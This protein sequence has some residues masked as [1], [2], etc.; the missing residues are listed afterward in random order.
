MG[1]AQRGRDAYIR[2]MNA[3]P[4]QEEPLDVEHSPKDEIDAPLDSQGELGETES[5]RLQ[6]AMDRMSKTMSTLSNVE[7]KIDDTD[8]SL[9]Q[10]LK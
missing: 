4:N 9:V 10:N 5:L 8:S 6:M 3:T 7:K 1:P 2:A